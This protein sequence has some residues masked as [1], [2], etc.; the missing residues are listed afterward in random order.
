MKESPSLELAAPEPLLP[1]HVATFTHR[2][3]EFFTDGQPMLYEFSTTRKAHHS[4]H[5]LLAQMSEDL[6][7][8]EWETDD[9]EEEDEE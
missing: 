2:L 7:K 4:T 9:E 6:E 3:N 1:C 8:E 5:A